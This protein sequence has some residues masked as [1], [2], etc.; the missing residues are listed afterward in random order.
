MAPG[1]WAAGSLKSGVADEADVVAKQM[2]DPA[3]LLAPAEFERF[4]IKLVPRRSVRTKRFDWTRD[5]PRVLV[6]Y[7]NTV[8]LKLSASRRLTRVLITY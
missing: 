3:P 1:Q 8:S 7:K 6:E 5:I 4:P 2:G